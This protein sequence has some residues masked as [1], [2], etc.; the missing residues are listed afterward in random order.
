MSTS[1]RPSAACPCPPTMESLQEPPSQAVAL[2]EVAPPQAVD[3]PSSLSACRLLGYWGE[4][5][6]Q[7]ETGWLLISMNVTL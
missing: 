3:L 5:N 2:R 7:K 6:S 4:E 1:P